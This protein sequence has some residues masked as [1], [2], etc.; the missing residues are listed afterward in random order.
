MQPT[1]RVENGTLIIKARKKEGHVGLWGSLGKPVDRK[2]DPKVKAR[3]EDSIKAK[4][5]QE[6]E[7][8]RGF[9]SCVLDT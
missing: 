3:R 4:L 6:Q 1:A 9:I 5:K 7:V 2:C 8:C